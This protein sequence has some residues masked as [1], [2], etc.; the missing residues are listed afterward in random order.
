MLIIFSL[1]RKRKI[2]EATANSVEDPL[3]SGLFFRLQP[4]ASYVTDRRSV[5]CHPQ[6]SNIYTVKGTKVIKLLISGDNWLDP[7]TF[8][9]CL[10]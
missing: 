2:M 9:I 1:Y 4:G 10:I 6:G 3:I 7:S 8:R 5:T